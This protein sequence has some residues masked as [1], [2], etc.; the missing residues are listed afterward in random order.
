MAAIK[1]VF[2]DATF[3][4]THCDP[5]TVIGSTCSLAPYLRLLSTFDVLDAKPKAEM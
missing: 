4:W 5:A 3:V 2:P 1:E